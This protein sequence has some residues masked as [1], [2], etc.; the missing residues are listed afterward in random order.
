MSSLRGMSFYSQNI[1]RPLQI[2]V[3]IQIKVSGL[4]IESCHVFQKSLPIWNHLLADAN[5]DKCKQRSD[6]AG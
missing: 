1:M 5:A 2:V 6:A 3:H 4:P